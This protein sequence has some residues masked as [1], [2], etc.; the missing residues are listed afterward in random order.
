MCRLLLGIWKA[1]CTL[2]V[3]TIRIF[4]MMNHR[5]AQGRRAIQKSS[6]H[7]QIHSAGCFRIGQTV[8]LPILQYPIFRQL[9]VRAAEQSVH[10]LQGF[11]TCRPS[12]QVY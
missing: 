12:R 9:F 11:F 3:D 10:V 5:S 8:C 1:A 2:L 7:I 4:A 6:L